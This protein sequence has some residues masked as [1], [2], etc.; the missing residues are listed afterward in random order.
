MEG[1]DI[2]KIRKFIERCE[3]KWAKSMI[4]IPHEYIVRGKCALSEDEFKC[5]FDAQRTGKHEV[6]RQYNHQYIYIDGWKYWTMGN[7]WEMT[8]VMNRA[9]VFDS[10]DS[11]EWPLYREYSEYEVAMMSE[12]IINSFGGKKVFE[13]GFGNGDFVKFSDIKPENYYGVDPSKKAIQLFRSNTPG[14]G[15]KC[16]RL[17]FEEANKRWLYADSVVIALFGAAS[18]FMYEYLNIL[19]ENGLDYCL[20]F[21]REGYVPEEFVGMYP[22]SY[23]KSDLLRMFPKARIY[24]HERYIT[25]SSRE[26]KW[27]KPSVQYQLFD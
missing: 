13:C 9:R 24:N 25:M 19:A 10:F 15:R 14:F 18:Y 6:W 1:F 23:K 11:F 16:S 4:D 17:S 21:Y 27:K 26:L 3:W 5:F 2:D 20:M 8:K 12:T 22:F 7:P